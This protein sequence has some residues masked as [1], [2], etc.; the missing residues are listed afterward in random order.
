MRLLAVAMLLLVGAAGCMG[1]PSVGPDTVLLKG[2]IDGSHCRASF[3]VG[4]LVAQAIGI[5]IQREDGKVLDIYWPDGFTGRR[6]GT[7]V[8]ILDGMGRVVA[9]TGQRYKLRG[10]GDGG[11]VLV[12]A[13][14]ILPPP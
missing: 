8:E 12:C 14:G 9:A 13:E 5:G 2:R 3:T 6:A 4:T 11:V 7:E 1:A 10:G